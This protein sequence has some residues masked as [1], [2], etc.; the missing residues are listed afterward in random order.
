MKTFEQ[1]YSKVVLPDQ[2]RTER[3]SMKIAYNAGARELQAE[4]ERLKKFAEGFIQD[5]ETNYVLDDGTIVDNP[6]ELLK[7][8]YELAKEAIQTDKP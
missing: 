1:W 3:E 5:F 4:N 2:L 7:I 6:S 8:N